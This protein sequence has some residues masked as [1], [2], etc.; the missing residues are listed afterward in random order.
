MLFVVDPRRRP[1]APRLAGLVT[2]TT[3]GKKQVIRAT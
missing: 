2:G 1:G 3:F